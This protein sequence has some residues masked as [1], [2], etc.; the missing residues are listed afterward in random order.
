MHL[1]ANSPTLIAALLMALA[2]PALA[3]KTFE[4]RTKEA[5]NAIMAKRPDGAAAFYSELEKQGRALAADFPD[6]NEAYDM[7]LAVAGQADAQKARAIV[8]EIEAGKAPDS[9]KERARGLLAKLDAVGKPLDIKFT[10]IDGREIDLAKMKGKVVL[11]DFWAVWCGP[12]VAEI[13]NVKKTYEQLQPQGFEIVG[14][15]FDQDKGKLESFVKDKGMAWPQYFDGK[16]WKNDFGVKYGINSIPAMWLVD[17]QGI[18]RDM[19]A[20]QDLAGKVE[21]LLAEK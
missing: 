5:R 14:I 16:G 20:R 15:S 12:C 6:K 3:E 21:K 9:A 10:A 17:K 7:L 11:V 18:L 1:P 2:I 19:N 4:E 8:G 13:P